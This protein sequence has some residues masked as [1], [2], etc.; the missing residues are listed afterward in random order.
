MIANIQQAC[1]SSSSLINELTK[2][3]VETDVNEEDVKKHSVEVGL[4]GIIKIYFF[5]VRHC[6]YWTFEGNT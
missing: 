1:K 3:H 4:T 5:S 6:K 2:Q